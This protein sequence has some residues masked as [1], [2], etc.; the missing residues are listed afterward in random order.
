M[1]CRSV[2]EI[3]RVHTMLARAT[4]PVRLRTR[5]ARAM[6]PVRVMLR[7]LAMRLVQ[8]TRPVPATLRA[9]AIRRRTRPGEGRTSSRR[10]RDTNR[11]RPRRARTGLCSRPADS[12]HRPRLDSVRRAPASR[13]RVPA[14]RRRAP[15]TRLVELRLP[16]RRR[17]CTRRRVR[18]TPRGRLLA[19]GM[20]PR[21]VRPT[22]RARLVLLPGQGTRRARRRMRR[23]RAGTSMGRIARRMCRGGSRW[24]PMW[25][26]RVHPSIAR[27]RRNTRLTIDRRVRIR[28]SCSRMFCWWGG[29]AICSRV[30]AAAAEC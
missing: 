1:L 23:A 12:T 30:G 5:R 22:R 8:A 9:L 27:V 11:L 13:L 14:S 7:A 3:W 4:M 17:L 24:G 2:R 15:P 18:A 28:E 6:H 19:P 25:R 10:A 20:L 29:S 16:A 21:R 26:A